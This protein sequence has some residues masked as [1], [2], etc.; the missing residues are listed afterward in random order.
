L[1]H[2]VYQRLVKT[3]ETLKSFALQNF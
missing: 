1:V 3:Q 2:Q